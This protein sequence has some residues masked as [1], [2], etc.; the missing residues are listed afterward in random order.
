MRKILFGI[1]VELVTF[2]VGLA[3][4]NAW[5]I[6]TTADN[7][8]PVKTVDARRIFATQSPKLSTHSCANGW[9]NVEVREF[10]LCLPAA[11]TLYDPYAGRDAPR[12]DFGPDVYYLNFS[13]R[14][15]SFT[16]GTGFSELSSASELFPLN[17]E[18][19]TDD[20][21]LETRAFVVIDGHLGEL[22]RLE[23]TSDVGKSMF[24]RVRYLDKV[25]KDF[26][27]V[28][29]CNK[30]ADEEMMQIIDSISFIGNR[31]R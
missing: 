14:D 31:W 17:S 13:N 16:V 9:Q 4:V 21:E 5:L 22:R 11:L 24:V 3:C 25:V 6:L 30:C 7:I 26:G 2:V 20:F 28:V 10:C 1:I 18:P 23:E 12:V 27:V 19:V 15:Q 8:P 29:Q